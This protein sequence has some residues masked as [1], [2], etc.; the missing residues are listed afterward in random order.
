VELGHVAVER[1]LFHAI[2]REQVGGIVG[3]HICLL[4][5]DRFISAADGRRDLKRA[6]AP[7]VLRISKRSLVTIHTDVNTLVGGRAEGFKILPTPFFDN[8]SGPPHH[9]DPALAG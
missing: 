3:G 4:G 7:H 5:A 1:S 2:V 9:R 6:D 8:A